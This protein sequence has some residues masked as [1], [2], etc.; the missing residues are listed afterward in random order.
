MPDSSLA[1]WPPKVSTQ[2][3]FYAAYGKGNRQE[4]GRWFLIDE[5]GMSGENI[6]VIED[7]EYITFLQGGEKPNRPAAMML[8]DSNNSECGVAVLTKFDEQEVF[9]KNASMA[10]DLGTS[11]TSF[12]YSIDESEPK[13]LLFSLSP[14][15]VWGDPPAKG[16]DEPG[17]VPF[18]WNVKKGFYPTILLSRKGVGLEKV[19][20]SEVQIKHV[21]QVDIPTLRSNIAQVMGGQLKEFWDFH[22][23]LKWDFDQQSAYRTLF[24]ER[25]LLYAHAE[26]FF[27]HHALPSSYVFTFPLAF[28]PSA[29]K[30]FHQEAR[31]TIEKL[32]AL[33]CPS[34]DKFNYVSEVDES[35]AIA[36]SSRATAGGKGILE[37]FVDIGGGTSDIA[38]RHDNRFLVLDSVRVAGKSFF[39]FAD[40]SFNEPVYGDA[41]FKKHLTKILSSTSEVDVEA[42]YKSSKQAV[43]AELGTIYS[44]LINQ[45]KDED[46]TAKEGKIL[47]E[48]MG[49]PS[50]I[51]YRSSLFFRH[52]LTYALIQACAA[53]IDNKATLSNGINIIL[54]GNAWGLLM[55]A[56]LR[57]A[58]NMIKEECKQILKYIVDALLKSESLKDEEYRYLEK[59]HVFNITLLNEDDLK[60]AKTSVAI[61]A[62]M[63]LT[64]NGQVARQP[65]EA[66]TSPYAG[67]TMKNVK[68]NEYDPITIRWCDRWGFQEIRHKV[69]FAFDQIDSF[70]I[71]EPQDLGICIDQLLSVF[72]CQCNIARPDKDQLPAEEWQSI[73]STLLA[74]GI[75]LQDLK[76]K[77]SPINY[78]LSKVLYPDDRGH[79][80]LEELAKINKTFKPAG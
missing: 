47:E 30:E 73:N 65:E 10:M 75:Y 19:K 31:R 67:I 55:F 74:G 18:S 35:T 23:N 41:Q 51:K 28:S 6:E 20:P 11:N 78:F 42:L 14:E 44:V 38:I 21:F 69:G 24:L 61:G 16:F 17:F 50:Y 34:A 33:C 32:R 37:V 52:I 68:I 1:L 45:T 71:E 58:K 66:S 3:H 36:A 64:R 79:Y 54:S 13:S 4:V 40:K 49:R 46:F 63:A 9:T 70:E 39:K 62:L 5:N 60:K 22:Q 72:T 48:G 26:M 7:Y 53:V 59:L 80:Y 76:P 57:R 12:A 25:S 56:E 43:N 2:W 29:R 27:T 8:K 77:Y 15:M